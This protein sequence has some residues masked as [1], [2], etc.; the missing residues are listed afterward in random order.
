MNEFAFG[1]PLNNLSTQLAFHPKG[2]LET[3][4]SCGA[5]DLIL[6]LIVVEY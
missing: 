6:S 3:F 1:V 2:K 4:K 5:V